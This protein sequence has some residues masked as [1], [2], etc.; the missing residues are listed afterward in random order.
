M[1]IY[2]SD[3]HRASMDKGIKRNFIEFIVAAMILNKK[4]LKE[5]HQ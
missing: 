5:G 1:A 2:E 3:N 4:L